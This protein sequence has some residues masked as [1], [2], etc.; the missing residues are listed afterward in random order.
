M[1]Y[2]YEYPRP[3]LTVDCV[4]FG[5]GDEGL[6]VLL[7]QRKGEPFKGKWAIPGGFVDLD[8]GLEDAARRELEEETG[9][10]DVPLEQFH[11]F[12]EVDRDPRGRTVSVAYCALVNLEEHRPR[13][14]SDAA[15]AAWFA[16]TETPELAFDHDLVLDMACQALRRKVRHESVGLGLPPR[17]FTLDQ[18]Q[19]LYEEVLDCR[20]EKRGTGAQSEEE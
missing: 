7:I 3:A 2:T 12:G 16:I 17:K 10:G 9:I 5:L 20:I 18:L 11:T 4:V 1:P 8:E 14:S 15:D 6:K 19:R 13:A